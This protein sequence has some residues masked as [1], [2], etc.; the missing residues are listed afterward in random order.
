M[1]NRSTPEAK[2]L[3]AGWKYDN[4]LWH[5]PETPRPG[6][7]LETALEFQEAKHTEC[8]CTH[9]HQATPR[10]PIQGC[11]CQEFRRKAQIGKFYRVPRVQEPG[12][13]KVPESPRPQV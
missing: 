8:L 10:C 2:L 4:G 11:G 12:V 5:H 3:M 7:S 1:F 9:Y 6:M 13:D